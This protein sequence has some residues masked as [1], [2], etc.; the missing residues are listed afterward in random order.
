MR[1][2]SFLALLS[3]IAVAFPLRAVS[4]PHTV[5][6]LTADHNEVIFNDDGYSVA[7]QSVSTGRQG[8]LTTHIVSD[9]GTDPGLVEVTFEL[10][11]SD[12]FEASGSGYLVIGSLPDF[13]EPAQHPFG[14]LF[15]LS[16]LTV[17]NTNRP[18]GGAWPKPGDELVGEGEVD[19]AGFL[20][21]ATRV[22]RPD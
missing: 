6:A 17:S 19:F 2:R 7:Y 8:V 22:V 21:G 10:V 20:E 14:H 11:Y 3:L 18:R 16:R 5:D 13:A 9:S 15:S 1:Q 4:G 12:G